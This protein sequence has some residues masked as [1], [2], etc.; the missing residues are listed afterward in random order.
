[1]LKH[2]PISCTNS[3]AVMFT[4]G[5]GVLSAFTQAGS[6]NLNIGRVALGKVLV[7]F[8]PSREQNAN[9]QNSVCGVLPDGIKKVPAALALTQHRQSWRMLAVL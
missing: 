7:E 1:M 5:A 9:R 6:T 8:G 2:H 3:F 4:L